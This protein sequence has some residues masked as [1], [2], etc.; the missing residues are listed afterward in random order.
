MLT[1]VVIKYAKPKVTRYEIK[2][3]SRPGLRLIVQPKSG[4]K[5][6]VY[7]YTFGHTYKKITL[8]TYPTMTLKAAIAAHRNAADALAEGRDPGPP[9]HGARAP[10]RTTL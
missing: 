8:G 2:D 4:A 3:A 6:F 5:S 10:L 9:Q 7:R 1:D